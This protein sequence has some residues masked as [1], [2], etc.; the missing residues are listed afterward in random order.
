[1]SQYLPTPP[2]KTSSDSGQS[3][4]LDRWSQR[5][6]QRLNTEQGFREQRQGGHGVL[7]PNASI[8][9]QSGYNASGAQYPIQQEPQAQLHNQQA[10]PHPSP[11]PAYHSE[12]TVQSSHPNAGLGVQTQSVSSSSRTNT[13][14]RQESSTPYQQSSPPDSS[15]YQF[16][17]PD[18]SRPTLTQSRSYNSQQQ[19]QPDT[20][21]TSMSSSNNGS[22]PAPKPLRTGGSNRQSMHNGI[23]SREGSGLGSGQQ[24]GGQQGGVPAFNASVVPPA[25]Q[26]QYQSSS[27]QQQKSG[28]VGRNTPQPMQTGEEMSEEDIAALIK[29]HKELRKSILQHTNQLPL[30]HDRR[31]IHQSQEVLLRE[32][33]SGQA[34]PEQPRPPT[35]IAVT[36]ITRRQRIHHPLQ[37]I[38]WS[39][40]AV[41]IQYSKELE[42]CTV[43][44]DRLSQQRRRCYRQA[45]DDSSRQS[46][47]IMLA[48]RRGL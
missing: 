24:S 36:N 26:A 29:E 9:E 15:G 42:E 48:G 33:G 44:V 11:Q 27:Q 21:V 6:L 43:M 47:H 31:E 25:G 22:L 5:R 30:T 38:G 34:A 39:C 45:R 2:R 40:G 3:A 18:S 46:I 28:D 41:G 4:A 35:P 7:S 19:Q 12:R 8:S 32:G 10:Q 1:M 20:D 14:Q 37:S 23:N 17:S 13:Y 16:S